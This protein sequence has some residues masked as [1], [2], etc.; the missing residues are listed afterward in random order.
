MQHNI[1]TNRA[2]LDLCGMLR[3][4]TYG[5][6]V[7]ASGSGTEYLLVQIPGYIKVSIII[8]T[9]RVHGA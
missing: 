8:R 3:P 6:T 9:V 1:R 5:D 4:S 7:C 2:E